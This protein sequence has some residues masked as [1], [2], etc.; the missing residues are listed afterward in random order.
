MSF[1]FNAVKVIDDVYWV[2]AIDWGIR[3]FHGYST[4]RGTTYNAFLIMAEKITLIDTVKRPFFNEMMSRIRSVIDPSEI[5]YIV[6]NHSEMD[7]S[8]SLDVTAESVKPEKIFA[9]ANGVKNLQANLHIKRELTAVKHGE[10]LSLGNMNL[11]FYETKLLHWPDSMFS[12]LVEKN[13]LFS[14]DAF[15]MHLASSERFDDELPLSVLEWEGAKYFANILLPYSDRIIK[16]A[17]Y[18]GELK[19]ELAMILP[20]HGPVWR[21]KLDWI[22]EKYVEWASQAL[23]RKVVIAYDTMWGSTEK[24]AIAI[25]EGVVSAG[26]DVKVMRLGASHRSDIVTELLDAAALVVGSP[27]LNNNL[28]PTVADLM[29]YIK[30][31]APQRRIGGVF[32]SFG[33]GGESIKQLVEMM[34]AM[35]IEL[36]SEPVGVKF[37]PSPEDLAK[38]WELG[39]AVGG[40]T[41]SL[42]RRSCTR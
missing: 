4:G 15:G 3:D 40:K 24:M 32:G 13:L 29:C 14:Q 25:A 1:V 8:G 34:G 7:H 36:A 18:L 20:D 16:L 38:C 39:S 12:Y 42:N 2:G 5:D 10:I 28:F 11:T 27:T 37:A 6:S 31:L 41:K 19:I 9:S 33:W 21:E 26:A 17:N 30:G 23:T 35:K 22:V